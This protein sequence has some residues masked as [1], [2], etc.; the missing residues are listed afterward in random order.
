MISPLTRLTASLLWLAVGTL[1]VAATLAPS[2]ADAQSTAIKRAAPPAKSHSKSVVRLPSGWVPNPAVSGKDAY[3][4]LDATSGRE[5]VADRADELRH[6]ASLTKLMTIY[7]TFSAL[8]SGRL[9]LGDAL[10]VSINALN[11]PPTKMG[12]PPGGTVNVRDAAMAL[13]TRSAN[14]AAVVL[15]EALGGDEATFAQLMT[16]KARQLGMSSTVY[17]NA[18]GLPNRDQVTTARDLARLAFAL[19]RDF[20]HYY[21]IFSVQSFPYRGRILENHNRMLLSYEGA[22]GLKTGYTAASGFNLVMSAMRDNRRLIGVVMGGDSAGQRDRMMADLMDYGFAS[23]QSMRL[24]PWTSLRKPPSARYT[25]A[26]FDPSLV[27]PEID[28][29]TC[30]GAGC[31]ACRAFHGAGL[32]P[33]AAGRSARRW[34]GRS[35]SGSRRV[36]RSVDRQLGDP[37]RIVQRFTGRPAC[38]GTRLRCPAQLHAF[39]RGRHRRRGA[40]GQQELPPRPP[41]QSLTGPGGRRLQAAREAQ[42]LLLGD[43]GH[44]LEYPGRALS[45]RFQPADERPLVAAL[46]ERQVP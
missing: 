15:A 32:Y 13:V 4:I 26:N 46:P 39:G 43:S 8:D 3:L 25:A 41:D 23:A 40:D 1:F 24:S 6:P 33:G 42:D 29:A 10:P 34:S 38:A 30:R 35:S 16:S 20:P 7:L 18:S 28:A 27:L 9:S 5:L 17:R 14:D 31:T 36:G 45:A 22:D 12:L 21:A 44:R 2:A 37:G 11:A 19:M